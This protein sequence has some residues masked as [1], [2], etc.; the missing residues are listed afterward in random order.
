V[1]VHGGTLKGYFGVW[2]RE[3]HTR[4]EIVSETLSSKYFPNGCAI[5]FWGEWERPR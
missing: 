1:D 4:K 2:S 3:K 5:G